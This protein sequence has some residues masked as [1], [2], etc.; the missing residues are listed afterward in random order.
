MNYNVAFDYSGFSIRL[1]QNRL[2]TPIASENLA[3]DF[4]GPSAVPHNDIDSPGRGR[5]PV[6]Q[7]VMQIYREL[8]GRLVRSVWCGPLPRGTGF[9]NR[10]SEEWW[11]SAL[12]QPNELQ[13][14]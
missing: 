5:S 14:K 13:R 9:A 11:V 12:Q 10:R 4:T 6:R 7:S 2:P 1:T 8:S 3:I